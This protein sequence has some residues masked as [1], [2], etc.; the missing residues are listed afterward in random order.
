ME[1]FDY[2]SFDVISKFLKNRDNVVLCTKLTRSDA[3]GRVNVEV[4]M[5]EKGLGWILC[6]LS[7]R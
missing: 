7:G 6:E 2:R 3:N 4:A 5:C 1:L